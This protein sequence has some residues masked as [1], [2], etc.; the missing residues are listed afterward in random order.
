M[1]PTEGACH[2]WSS[3]GGDRKSG[4][5]RHRRMPMAAD[6]ELH[7]GAAGGGED[8]VFNGCSKFSMHVVY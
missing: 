5:L 7:G 6:G 4:L 1:A 2:L 8:G 3:R